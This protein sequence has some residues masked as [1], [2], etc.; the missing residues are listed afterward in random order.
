[1]EKNKGQTGGP[2]VP[3][4]PQELEQIAR[5]YNGFNLFHK[6]QM[7]TFL[8]KD[9][10]IQTPEGELVIPMAACEVGIAGTT[11]IVKLPGAENTQSSE[12]NEPER[13][14]SIVTKP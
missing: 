8:A 10:L 14:E 11:L 7:L 3:V 5:L 1:V 4:N 6:G 9:V 13:D 12:S 2:E